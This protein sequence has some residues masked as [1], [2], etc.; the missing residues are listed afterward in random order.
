MTLLWPIVVR[1]PYVISC[2][3]QEKCIFCTKLSLCRTVRQPHWCHFHQFILLTK[4]PICKILAK[5]YWELEV[6]E[7]LSFFWVG[8]FDFF[9]NKKIFFFAFSYFNHSQINGVAW[10]GLIFYDYHDFQKNHEGFR[11]MKHNVLN[12]NFIPYGW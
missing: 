7:K 3:K 6:L 1:L 11:I 12:R 10:M 4:G 2:K 9:F 5:K 8:H